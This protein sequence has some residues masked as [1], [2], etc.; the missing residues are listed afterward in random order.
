MSLLPRFVWLPPWQILVGLPRF[1]SAALAIRVAFVV[2]VLSVQARRASR[3]ERFV[4]GVAALSYDT[5]VRHV[6]G[7]L[8]LS[9]GNARTVALSC[10]S[11]RV[12][13]M[14]I[15]V[16]VQWLWLSNVCGVHRI[17]LEEVVPLSV[18]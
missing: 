15:V 1:P 18:K 5:C 2:S 12:G 10:R 13:A 17:R 6:V 4:I 11:T 3:N 9:T 8:A 14:R 7:V 16:F